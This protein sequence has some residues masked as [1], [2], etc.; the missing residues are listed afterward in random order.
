MM[1][2]RALTAWRTACAS[3][4]AARYLAREDASHLVMVGAGALAPHL[5]RAHISVRP[6]KRVTLW[7]RTRARAVSL[8]FG[9]AVAGIEVDIA[10]T[11]EEAVREAD[12]V[13]CATLAAEPLIKGAWLKKGAHLDLVGGFTPKMREADD[14]GSQARAYLRRYPRRRGQGGRRYRRASEE[15]DHRCEGDQGRS[16]RPLPRQGE[17][18]NLSLTNHACSSRSEQR[19]RIWR[20]P[21]WSGNRYRPEGRQGRLAAVEPRRP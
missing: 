10:E 14:R 20:R 3:A 1:D 7:N 13:S 8:G 6:I 5:I 16:V 18:P 2:G 19:S 17:G 21:C 4:L 11:L 12:I 15:E 9:I